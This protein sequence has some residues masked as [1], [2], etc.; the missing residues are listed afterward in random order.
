MALD[1]QSFPAAPTTQTPA[2]QL[3]N[4]DFPP[5]VPSALDD[6]FLTTTLNP[7]W[8]WANQSTT[9][10]TFA[11][12]S[13]IFVP[14]VAN[15]DNLRTISQAPPL[16]PWTIKTKV[17]LAFPGSDFHKAGICLRDNAGGK[18]L[19]LV[20][21]SVSS[22]YTAILMRYSADTTF[23]TQALNTAL[24]QRY[25]YLAVSYDGTTFTLYYSLDGIVYRSLGT[26]T[27]ANYIV[28]LG[29][30]GL[31]AE[32]HATSASQTFVFDWFRVTRSSTP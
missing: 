27:L 6:E 2:W 10:L 32:T 22:V 29:A 18:S 19:N 21:C 25:V 17:Q 8:T 31:V 20:I 16:S 12:S 15:T 14:P 5:L 1:F 23:A 28:T 9:A 30:I 7:K 13:A 24:G 26:E 4:P 11:N 3:Q